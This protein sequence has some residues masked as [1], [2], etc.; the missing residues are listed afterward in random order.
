[1]ENRNR[2]QETWVDNF[3]NVSSMGDQ[4]EELRILAKNDEVQR[5]RERY[6]DIFFQ[7]C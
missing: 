2:G 4:L 3:S 5:E 1:M 6:L 7:S